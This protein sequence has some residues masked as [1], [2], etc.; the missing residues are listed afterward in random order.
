MMCCVFLTRN[1]EVYGSNLK[2]PHKEKMKGVKKSIS[3]TY[4]VS[5]QSFSALICSPFHQTWTSTTQTL[6]NGGWM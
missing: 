4:L 5:L 2:A 1:D 3:H 6:Q